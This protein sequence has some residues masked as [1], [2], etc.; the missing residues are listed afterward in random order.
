MRKSEVISEN[1]NYTAINIGKL[2]DL[3]DYS[4]LHPKSGQEIKGKIFLKEATKATGTEISFQMLPPHT[5]LTYF[6]IHHKNEETYI[7]LRGNGDFQIDDNCFPIQEGSIVR[8][9]PAGNRSLRNSSDEP[10]I[11]MVIQSKENSLEEYSS[12]DG[13]RIPQEIKW[14]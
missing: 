1:P 3:M 2:D 6:H 5:P 10:M 4:M 9:S 14:E 11:Y 12:A 7:I 13:E 8:V